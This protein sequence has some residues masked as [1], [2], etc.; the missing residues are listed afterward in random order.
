MLC[1]TAVRSRR[2]SF[3]KE[4]GSNNIDSIM[5]LNLNRKNDLEMYKKYDLFVKYLVRQ[6][7][8]FQMK[9]LPMPIFS[10]E[11]KISNLKIA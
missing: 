4:I 7:D 5:D 2:W 9:K 10:E 8:V 1:V 6:H 11:E 3:F